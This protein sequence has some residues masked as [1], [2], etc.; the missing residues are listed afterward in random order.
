MFSILAWSLVGIL[1]VIIAVS[2][3]IISTPMTV[4]A[5]LKSGQTSKM[6]ISVSVLGGLWVI[7][8]RASQSVEKSHSKTPR[9]KRSKLGR[10][11]DIDWRL[12]LQAGPR[13]ISR[14]LKR[15][16]L[17]TVRAFIHYGC[18]DPADTGL[19][20]GLTV[21]ITIL[22]NRRTNVNLRLEPDF[23]R[24]CFDGEGD[25]KARFIPLLILTPLIGF[26]WSIFGAPRFK[27][28]FT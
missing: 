16:E 25:I 2:L 7:P 5:H 28:V 9:S 21:P 10:G 17:R 19:L 18:A 4:N 20:Y 11:P 24:A 8:L 23:T 26:A 1:A 15:I 14:I 22:S 3:A 6:I 12:A 27:Q 13:L